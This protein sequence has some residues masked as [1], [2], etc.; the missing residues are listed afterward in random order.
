MAD[1]QQRA[2]ASVVDVGE[3]AGATLVSFARETIDA[4]VRDEARPDSPTDGEEVLWTDRGAFVTVERGDQ[5]RGCC[6]RPVAD[7]PLIE[8]V[9]SVAA[10]AAVADPR[11]PPLS[12][13]ELDGVTISVSV[14]SPLE[15]L[16]VEPYRYP[17]VV[18]VGRDGLYVSRGGRS[19]LLLPSVAAE[20][21]WDASTFLARTC[22]KAGLPT[23][24]WQDP[25][26]D[27]ER[28]TAT[29]FA[30]PAPGEPPAQRAD[31]ENATE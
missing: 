4:T 31:D 25:A 7:G 23:D 21:D 27:V 6:G 18:S 14:L 5:L 16:S 12:P 30:E 24:A 8:T 29:V 11:F 13:A 17:N 20:R 3:P 28:F 10:S 15:P 22:E 26:T 19:G 1:R 2:D 9:G